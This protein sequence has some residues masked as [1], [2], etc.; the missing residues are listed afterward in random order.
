MNHFTQHLPGY[1]DGYQRK[2]FD[3]NGVEEL[4]E[5][6]GILYGDLR[7]S[8]KKSPY[9]LLIVSKDERWW[10]VLGH[11]TEEV[12]IPYWD[13]DW[14]KVKNDEGHVFEIRSKDIQWYDGI[15]GELKD[16]TKVK[17]MS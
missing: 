4:C 6:L 10:W 16:G 7:I 11:I 1:I 5:K 12:D 8:G 3:F 2:E 15:Q 13:G 14:H 9:I 17:F